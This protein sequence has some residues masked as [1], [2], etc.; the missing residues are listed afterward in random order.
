MITI[1]R[2][3]EHCHSLRFKI[4]AAL[5]V[6]LAASLGVA[7]FGIWTYERDQFIDMINDQAKRGGHAIEKA[8][9]VSMLQ[10]DTDAI[11][12]AIN[13]IAA[14]DEPPARI[15][16]IDRNGRVAT[17]ND[18]ALLGQ[19]FDLFT[20][21]SCMVCHHSRNATPA[22][23]AILINNE[24]G[25]VLRNIIKINNRPE[26][27]QCHPAATK[28]LGVLLYD[29]DFTRSYDLL[30]TVA[31]RVFL[32][33][34][35]TFMAI[36][37]VLFLA[38]NRLIHTPLRKLMRGFT[39]AGQGN[40]DFWVEDESSNE[41]A[42]MTDQFNVMNRAIGRFI[43]EIKSKNEETTILYTFVREVSETIEWE[44]LQK[45]VIELV[46]NLFNA[47]QVGL[48]MPHSQ[49]KDCSNILWREKDEKR[50]SR[51][52]SC[53]D[54]AELS[55]SAV[56]T[57]ELREWQQDR[58]VAHRFKDD[59]Q[60][61]LIPLHYS[62]QRLGL[63]CIQKVAGQR[64]SRNERSI[65][66]ALANHIAISLAN[67][68]LYHM[69]I[70]DGLTE[71]YSKRHLLN[72]LDILVAKKDKY[73]GELFF[74]LM[75]DLDHFKQVNDTYGHEVGDQ[76]LIQLAE[77]LRKNIRFEDTPFRYGGEEFI[78]LVPALP[79]DATM[80][81]GIMIAERLREAVERHTFECKDA[82]PI[83]KT[84]SIGVALFPVHGKT[85]HDIIR[86]ADE[87]LYQAK[88]N[89]RNRVYGATTAEAVE[90]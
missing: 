20:S 33:G 21:P 25:Q 63:I 49:K 67:A 46:H 85:A 74:V 10:N 6:V 86:V 44:R 16:I 51:L 43:N 32:S 65:I 75:L 76:V 31:F 26:C 29:A 37:A 57:K 12:T 39:Q 24:N 42:Y 71:L 87:S 53:Q 15:S 19:T 82:P 79:G 27:H 55:F 2:L 38:L 64:F 62:K 68:H 22:E 30:R 73:A 9:R 54:S 60:R 81:L 61:L 50:L 83:R 47:Q 34:L 90:K 41:F 72:K 80:S 7:M 1:T 17:G 84:I 89:G 8:L 13:E 69:A 88:H 35:V 18:P 66:P 77:L 28:I 58:F 56:T 5:F 78:I 11:R 45:I 40:Y 48:V 36:S 3:I 59:Y 23:E 4:A 52:L 70:T 14:I